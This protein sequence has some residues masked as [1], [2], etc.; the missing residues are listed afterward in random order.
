MMIEV[1]STEGLRVAVRP[2]EVASVH[3]Y[4]D[5]DEDDTITVLVTLKNGVELHLSCEYERFMDL[6][7]EAE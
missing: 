7:T 2:G 3:E 4:Q 6:L 1:E 5:D